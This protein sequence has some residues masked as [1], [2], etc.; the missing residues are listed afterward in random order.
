MHNIV[1]NLHVQLGLKGKGKKKKLYEC[2]ER[3]QSKKI[4]KDVKLQM[5]HSVCILLFKVLFYTIFFIYV[6]TVK[7]L[8]VSQY[9]HINSQPQY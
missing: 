1:K 6:P 3:N 8:L 9:W 7:L 5:R 4:W 2:A